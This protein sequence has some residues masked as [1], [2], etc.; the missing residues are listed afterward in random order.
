[1]L[2]FHQT[3]NL[4]GKRV[5]LVTNSRAILEGIEEWFSPFLSGE[6][7]TMVDFCLFAVDEGAF[8]LIIP[9]GAQHFRS[10][11][12][13]E[14]FL[15]K[16][17]W[18]IDFHGRGRMA[19]D[20]PRELALGFVRARYLQE[21]PWLLEVLAQPLFEL[22][23]RKELYRAHSG[24]VSLKGNGFLI[25][26]ESQSGK[27]TLVLHLVGE[28]FEFLCDDHCFLGKT[29]SG[30]EAFPFREQVRVYPGNVVHIPQ[31]QFLQSDRHDG[32]SKRSF[33]IREI[34]PDSIVDRAE[35]KVIIFP[36]WSSDGGSRLEAISPG[37]AMVELLPLTLEF[38]FPDTARAHFKFA[39]DLVEQIPCFRLH[40][41]NDTGKWHR[42]V[43]GLVQ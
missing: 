31:F 32:K 6:T 7:E 17:F 39:G 20:L 19:V 5:R 1:M 36:H 21:T 15:Y 12:A 27:T 43:K 2:V 29:A 16:Q 11:F 40:L 24:V 34:Y 13:S 14:H 25:G 35:L 41:G 4:G 18:L 8:P 33:D 26:G 3:F 30:F 37:E 22:L 9:E 38:I 42:L 23:R 10:E 28:G